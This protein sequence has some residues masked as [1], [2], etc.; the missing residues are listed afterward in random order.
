MTTRTVSLKMFDKQI[1]PVR[2]KVM[3][4][5]VRQKGIGMIEVLVGLFVLAI[6]LLGFAG[7]QNTSLAFGQKAYSNSQAAFMAQD[8]LERMRSNANVASSYAVLFSDDPSSAKNCGSTTETCS[9]GEMANWD[10]LQ[11]KNRLRGDA[12]EQAVLPDA[13]GQVSVTAGGAG[14]AQVEVRVQY[15]LRESRGEDQAD[16]LA[17][18][19]SLYEYVMRS[20]L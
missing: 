14:V 13:D 15:R 10:L 7:L 4:D 3:N 20:F 1:W 9:Q 2:T 8:I 5:I 18:D 16:S 6:G 17:D 19:G 12:G 11:W